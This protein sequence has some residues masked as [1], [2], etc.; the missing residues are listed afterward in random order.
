MGRRKQRRDQNSRRG[1]K[2]Y[3]APTTSVRHAT[4]TGSLVNCSRNGIAIESDRGMRIGGR[5]ELELVNDL[6]V[7]T[8]EATVRWCRLRSIRPGAIAG[9]FEPLF[10]TGLEL[11]QPR[12]ESLGMAVRR[13]GDGLRQGPDEP[14]Q[15]R[16]SRP[17][18]RSTHATVG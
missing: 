1:S 17:A 15:N 7:I 16:P 4:F 14:I 3:G 13:M 12:S 5:Y 9:D 10:V 11:S 18:S 8:V 2:R 6:L